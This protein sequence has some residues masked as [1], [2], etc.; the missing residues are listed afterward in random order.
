[1]ENIIS[2]SS[3][4]EKAYKRGFWSRIIKRLKG[5]TTQL[6]PFDEVRDRFP[7]E[8]QHYLG[9]KTIPIDHIVGSLGRYRDFDRA[10]LPVRRHIKNRWIKIDEAWLGNVELP[11]VDLYKIGEIYFVKDGNHRVSVA[12]ENGQEFI[13]AY[14][15][16]IVIPVQL[17]INTSIGDLERKGAYSD[18]LTKTGI[19]DYFPDVDLELKSGNYYERKYQHIDD[20]FNYLK[21]VSDGNTSYQ[22]AV[23]S[24]YKHIYLPIVEEVEKSGIVD[25]FKGFSLADFYLW[26]ME[27]QFL[28]KH[29]YQDD[30]TELDPNDEVLIYLRKN[31]PY[32][33]I[34]R[35]SQFIRN[36]PRITELT[37]EQER[38]RFYKYTKLDKIRP[39]A[40]ISPTILGQ[41]DRL[42]KHIE[43]HRWYLGEREGRAIPIEKAVASWYDNVYLPLVEIIR[44]QHVLERFPDRTETDLY[45]WI[46]THKWYLSQAYG[47]PVTDEEAVN[48][49]SKGYAGNTKL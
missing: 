17:S 26:I 13:D 12:R 41:Y 37:M 21:S 14:V 16:E 32:N 27:Y 45:I 20:H 40:N 15:T 49:F 30:D 48:D 35:L 4:F 6:L 3:D 29:A 7:L 47:E 9:L 25:D 38:Y 46:I 22:Q 1:M 5:E 42:R 33:F 34:I 39:E 18:F 43:V 19:K 24:W 44:N 28:L 31:S 10:F 23:T 2:A 8:G 36:N 11:P